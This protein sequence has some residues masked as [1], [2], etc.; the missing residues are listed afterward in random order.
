MNTLICHKVGSVQNV[1]L[2]IGGR[3]VLG[4][5]TLEHLDSFPTNLAH[6]NIFEI[7]EKNS[8]NNISKVTIIVSIL[9]IPKLT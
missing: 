7:A 3:L 1:C 8:T 9:I 6:T 5:S 2:V 4:V